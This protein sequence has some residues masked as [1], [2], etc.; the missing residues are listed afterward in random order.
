MM[1][2]GFNIQLTVDQNTGFID[3]GNQFNCLTWMDKMGSSHRAG[4]KGYP[5]TPRAGQPVQ[6]V[7]LLYHCLTSLVKLHEEGH[8]PYEEVV[9]KKRKIKYSEWALKIK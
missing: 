4:N 1:T 2:E 7:G 6:L 8:Y 3:G 5:A 9:F